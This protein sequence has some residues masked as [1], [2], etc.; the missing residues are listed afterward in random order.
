MNSAHTLTRPC[1][2]GDSVSGKREPKWNIEELTDAEVYSAIRYLDVEV[3]N[4]DRSSPLSKAEGVLFAIC[5]LLIIVFTGY[6]AYFWLY[7]PQ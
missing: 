7:R 4:S 6:L 2:N 1:I 5:I 3:P